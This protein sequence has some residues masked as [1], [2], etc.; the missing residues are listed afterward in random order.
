MTNGT[1]S[2]KYG[3]TKQIYKKTIYLISKSHLFDIFLNKKE[4]LL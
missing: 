2:I 3:I 1:T 4:S